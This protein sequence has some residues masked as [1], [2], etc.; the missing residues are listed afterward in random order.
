MKKLFLSLA[1]LLA[2][3]G[4]TSSKVDYESAKYAEALCQIGG[5][6]VQSV[7]VKKSTDNRWKESNVWIITAHCGYGVTIIFDVLEQERTL[8]QEKVQKTPKKE[9]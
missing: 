9:V 7:D 8:N 5:L 6:T 4:C 1:F 3:A 2:L